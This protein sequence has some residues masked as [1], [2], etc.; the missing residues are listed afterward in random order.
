MNTHENKKV[1]DIKINIFI[2]NSDGSVRVITEIYDET[3]ETVVFHEMKFR[4][5]NEKMDIGE[6]RS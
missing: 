1:N 5:I 3:F 4:K 6:L 2:T